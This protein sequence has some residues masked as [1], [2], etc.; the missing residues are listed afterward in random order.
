MK[1]PKCNR[2]KKVIKGT[3]AYLKGKAYHPNCFDKVKHGT[4]DPEVFLRRI[5]AWKKKWIVEEIKTTS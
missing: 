5:R 3:V 1:N 2:C 4:D